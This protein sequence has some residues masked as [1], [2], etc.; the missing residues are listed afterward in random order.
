MD[1]VFSA[2]LGFLW[3][4]R[5]FLDRIAAAKAAGFTV[6]EFHDDAQSAEPEALRRALEGLTVAGLNVRH[7]D[8][9]GISALAGR[10]DEARADIV[11]ATALARRV[12]AKAVHVM[13]GRTRET[14]AADRLAARLKEA[15]RAA[16]DLTFLV[17][18][19]CPQA[20]PGYLVPTVEAAA[21][22]IAAAGEPNVKIMFDCF[23]VQSAGG[24]VLARFRR[25]QSLVGHVQIAGGGTR[26]EPD[27]GELDY[28]WLIPAIQ[29][30]GYEGPFGAEY[31][32]SGPT[33]ETLTWR[34]AYDWR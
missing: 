8:T 28:R 7:H 32:P 4:D 1:V 20:V 11:E 5:P 31:V 24:D 26:A 22:I 9:N 3:K 33:D 18:P 10:E 13:A 30:A 25:Y 27:R 17:E 2:N 12:G 6:V 16:P 21:E 19:L 23:H 15:A 14:P 29:N 34:D